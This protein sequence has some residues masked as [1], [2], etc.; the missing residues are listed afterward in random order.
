[1]H[2]TGATGIDS[3]FTWPIFFVLTINVGYDPMSLLPLLNL[4][5][6][7]ICLWRLDHGRL[8]RRRSG[9]TTTMYYCR[10]HAVT[11][12]DI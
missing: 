5:S 10:S 9:K 2:V 11:D 8:L 4:A 6:T 1:M 12:V 3:P 7:Y